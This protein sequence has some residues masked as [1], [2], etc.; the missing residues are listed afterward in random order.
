VIKK[1]RVPKSSVRPFPFSGISLGGFGAEEQKIASQG[2]GLS[3]SRLSY[4]IVLVVYCLNL[5]RNGLERARDWNG[6]GVKGGFSV[7]E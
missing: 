6:S 2:V 4:V 1:G 5:V 7:R 3:Q